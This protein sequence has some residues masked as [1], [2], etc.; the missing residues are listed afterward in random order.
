MKKLIRIFTFFLIAAF[1]VTACG[2]KLFKKDDHGS[3]PID[4]PTPEPTN[5]P[6]L[7]DGGVIDGFIGDWYGVYSVTE[8]K[9]MYAPNAGVRNDCAMR[10][11]VDGYGRGTCYLQV[12]GMGR[13]S[14]SGSSNVFALCSA[15]ISGASL[16]IKGMIN[17]VSVD[18]A[19]ELSE[20]GLSLTEVYGDVDDHMRIE[21]KL[22]RPD[23]LAFS[24]LEPDAMEYLLEKGFAGVVDKLGGRTSELPIVIVSG[25]Y[26]PHLFFEEAQEDPSVTD[27][28]N[29]ITSIDGHIKVS[30]PEGYSIVE[31][32]VIDFV[33]S[34]PEKRVRSVEFTVSAWNTDGLSF[35]L[36]NTPNVT[37]LYHYTIDGFDFYGTFI[38]NE[39]AEDGSRTTIFKLCGTNDTGCLII[40]TLTLDMDAYSAYSYV[41]VDNAAFTQLVLGAKFN[42]D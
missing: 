42:V 3:D 5:E 9:G 36:G 22:V 6:V 33:I 31:N 4:I 40:I 38:E 34:C 26:D 20:G 2:C 25:G 30:L 17:T 28:P 23:V 21:I 29:T 24:G 8:A 15:E 27:S 11:S 32:D 1:I 13:D 10:V 14:V 39:P 37:E 12:N 16:L 18:W 7:L 41:N 19:F 35:L